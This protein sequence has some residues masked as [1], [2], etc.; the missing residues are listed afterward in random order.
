MDADRDDAG[1]GLAYFPHGYRDTEDR[2]LERHGQ[3]VLDH[4]G[5]PGQLLVFVVTV[6]VAWAISAS[7]SASLNSL[8]TASVGAS[9]LAADKGVPNRLTPDAFQLC[10]AA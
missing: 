8:T 5:E 3:V 2:R 4:G 7:S 9:R 6:T 1:S 10:D